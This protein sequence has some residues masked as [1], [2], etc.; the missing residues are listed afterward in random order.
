MA[1]TTDAHTTSAGDGLRM[2]PLDAMDVVE[3]F[4]PRHERAADEFAQLV[5]TVRQYGVLQPVLV[6]PEEDGRFRLTAGEGRFRAALEAGDNEIPAR[7][8]PVADETGGVELALIE[9]LVRERLDPVDE[10]RGYQALIDRG[11][12]VR[13]IA[14]RLPKTRRSG[15]PSAWRSSSCP[16]RS[17]PR[18]RTGRSRCRQ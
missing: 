12:N 9:A 14:Q 18:S 7:V 16:P 2:I 3:G 4:N 15:S 11:L 1:T 8:R 17:R 10:A 5:A 13:G 6:A